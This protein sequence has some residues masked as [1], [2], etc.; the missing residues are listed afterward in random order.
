MAI[1]YLQHNKTQ[2]YESFLIALFNSVKLQTI[3]ANP[4]LPNPVLALPWRCRSL[5]PD[6]PALFFRFPQPEPAAR[7]PLVPHHLQPVHW[8][9]EI[10]LV[11]GSCVCMKDKYPS[12]ELEIIHEFWS[13]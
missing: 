10:F 4:N 12:V 2:Y 5:L 8:W 9:Q 1:V 7:T 6:F 11:R 3:L 13:L